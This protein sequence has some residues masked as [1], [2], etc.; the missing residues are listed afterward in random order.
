[1]LDDF[2]SNILALIQ[3]NLTLTAIKKWDNS[4][5]ATQ[6]PATAT[7]EELFSPTKCFLDKR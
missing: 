6:I 4:A 5:V 7:Q 2:I 3:T 1:M